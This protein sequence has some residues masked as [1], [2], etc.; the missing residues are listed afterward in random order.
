MLRQGVHFHQAL[1]ADHADGEADIRRLHQQQPPP[2]MLT[3][4]V[5][6]DNRRAQHRQQR[7]EDIAPTQ[8]PA[9]QQVVDQRDVQRRQHGEQQ[10]FRHRQVQIGAEAEQV[11]DAQLE[12]AH[13]HIQQDHLEFDVAPTQKRQKHQRRQPDAHQRRESAVDVARQVLANQ[14]ERKCPQNGG[15]NQKQHD[16]FTLKRPKGRL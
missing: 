15:Y 14:A 1:I 3:Q 12:G 10:E 8:T 13:Q 6:A 11:H 5:I 9:A 4:L 2:E 16:G 7:A